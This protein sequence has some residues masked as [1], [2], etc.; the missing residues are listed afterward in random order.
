MK[1]KEIIL[2][3]VFWGWI[4]GQ[5]AAWAEDGQGTVNKVIPSKYGGNGS[6]NEGANVKGVVT[7]EV[8]GMPWR[9]G[10]QELGW[11]RIR[12]WKEGTVWAT[13]RSQTGTGQ[14]QL[15]GLPSGTVELEVSRPGFLDFRQKLLLQAGQSLSVRVHL[16][17]D[18]GYGLIVLPRLGT[19][20]TS[21]P[22]ERFTV[23]CRGPE[24]AHQWRLMLATDY[25][26]RPLELLR[27]E[28]GP[29]AVWNRT[30]PG[31][32]LTV[33]VPPGTPAEMYDLQVE[34][35]DA[36]ARRHSS[37][38]AKA[39]CIQPAYPDNFLLMPYQD[40]HLNWFVDKPG[41]AGE[42]QADYFRAA[43]L[44]DPFFVSLGDDIGFDNTGQAPGDDAVAMLHYF[45]RE[46]LDVPVYLAFGNHD[47]ALTVEGHEFYF[48]PRWQL[49]RIGPHVG[50]VISYD[51]YQAK[52]EMPAEQRRGVAEM[53]A[54]LEADP[55]NRLI[56]LAGHRS[57]FPP[58][59][60]EPF[61]PLPFTSQTRSWLPGNR[62]D[63][64][65]VEFQRLFMD[66]LSVRSMHGWGGLNY[67]G[68]IVRMEQWRRAELLPQAALPAVA[69][70][71]PNQGTRQR[72]SAAVRRVG[73]E[74]WTPPKVIPGFS[75]LPSRWEGLPEIRTARLRFVMPRGDY[76][77]RGGRIVQTVPADHGKLILIYVSIDL[78][79]PET[80][81]T[82]EPALSKKSP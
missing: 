8:S 32:Q 58:E 17:P 57:A 10:K 41:P 14:F 13:T 78:L 53:L 59:K 25:F 16:E 74:P 15:L 65:S 68:R 3:V 76:Q 23:E 9:A 77:C 66:A 46:Y 67:T 70:D 18:P 79:A 1:S 35:Q 6:L 51:L 33:R 40:F 34:F 48:G 72:V 82:V 5:A 38:Q 24:S 50:I 56:F 61:F 42:V 27:A 30:Q 63:G 81:V 44:L 26:T 36:E 49:R 28:Y 75:Q 19:A 71:G 2:R 11:A 69:W 22:R 55:Q 31:W 52:Y 62:D 4:L 45:V 21:I 12:V 47:A 54:Q 43:S 80:L 73:Q 20:I 37:R 60:H 7:G 29:K 39:V 64:I